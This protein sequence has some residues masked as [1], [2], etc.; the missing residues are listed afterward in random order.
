MLEHH[1]RA[2]VAVEERDVG[3]RV[4]RHFPTGE[5]SGDM[6]ITEIDELVAGPVSR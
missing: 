4:N 6:I 2:L 1:P 3:Y 5:L